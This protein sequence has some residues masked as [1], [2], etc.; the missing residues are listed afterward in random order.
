MLYGETLTHFAIKKDLIIFSKILFHLS[1]INIAFNSSIQSRIFKKLFFTIA[2]NSS[3][4]Q[5]N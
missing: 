5:K 2:D 4:T 1:S 3:Q